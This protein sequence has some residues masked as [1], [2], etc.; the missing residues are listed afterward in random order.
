MALANSPI[1]P[2][3]SDTLTKWADRHITRLTWAF[4]G[5]GVVLRIGQYA[6]NFPLWWDEAFVAV[7]L[8]RRDYG[9]LLHPL[10]Y[11]QVCPV[12]FLWAELT[13][14][15]LFGFSEWTLR[16][17]PLVSAIG[18]VGLFLYAA[19][20][21]LRGVPLLFAV[22]IFAVA[23]HPI[24][25]GADVKPY[26][27]DLMAA[28]LILAPALDC[29]RA[30]GRLRPLCWL[31]M[32]T[33][34]AITLSYPAIFVAGGT[35][36]ALF[37]AIIRSR[38]HSL[39]IAFLALIV[40]TGTTFG[41]IYLLVTKAQ[42]AAAFTAMRVPWAA[43]FPPLHSCFAL[44]RWLLT[45]HTGDMFAYPC[46]GKNG[47]SSPTTIL[48]VVGASV[49]WRRGG[50]G[51]V[52]LIFAPFGLALIAAALER[53]PYGGVVDGSPARI[54]QYLAPGICMLTAVGIAFCFDSLQDPSRR[55]RLGGIFLVI[56][57]AIGVIPLVTESFHPYRS[58]QAQ[59]ARE[60]AR[61][62]WPDFTRGASPVCF[63]WDVD[64]NGWG[65]T[66]L[67]MAVYLC[68]QRI[69][70]PN[71]WYDQAS[72]G[73]GISADRALRVVV[74]MKN[75]ADDDVARW[76]EKLNRRYKLSESHQIVLDTSEPGMPQ[77]TE[78]YFVYEFEKRHPLIKSSPR[79]KSA[80]TEPAPQCAG[81]LV[82]SAGT[83]PVAVPFK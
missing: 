19:G 75:P 79:S 82:S 67:N 34:I 58:I 71:R 83:G 16:L 6:L 80:T 53:Y 65:S 5:L 28:L 31:A 15:K 60:F 81:V 73:R 13:V 8:I 59:R 77:R 61:T 11:G 41:A 1:H 38:R 54:M 49:L 29:W 68:N 55:Q 32:L 24:R 4:V 48:F 44:A 22:A 20:R 64:P 26:A 7:N 50:R 40:G 63:Q 45:V 57:A 10:D 36:I 17:F 51:A 47:G 72:N 66:N 27:S 43:G 33:P 23:H 37:P 35:A 74:P 39:R 12:L 70:A 21:V 14:V 42:E 78:S 2:G 30:P 46:G 62:F 76:L 52:T 56:L 69:Y 9:G 18:S 25:H 3:T